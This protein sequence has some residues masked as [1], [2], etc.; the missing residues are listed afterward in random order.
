MRKILYTNISPV[1]KAYTNINHM[2]LV[3]EQNPLKCYMC[4]W[5]NFVF[6]N[7]AFVSGNNKYSKLNENTRILE[8]LLNSFNV[9]YKKFNFSEAW[10]RLFRN[11]EFSTAYQK[12][13]SNIT[14]HDIKSGFNLKYSPFSSV[15][16]SKINYIIADYLIAAFLP[17]LFPELC[18]TTPTH[19]L[20]S[21]R[22]KIFHKKISS[23]LKNKNL[24]K[25]IY[26]TSI[27]IIINPKTFDIP[28]IGDSGSFIK[29]TVREYMQDKKI[30]PREVNDIL[31]TLVKPGIKLEVKGKKLNFNSAFNKMKSLDK[32]T[33]VEEL[34]YNL[35]NYFSAVEKLEKKPKR[36]K[37]SI[38]IVTRDDFIRQVKPLNEMKLNILSYCDGTN[39]SL[40]ISNRTGIK[41]STV[42]TYFSR[43][44]ER[45][46]ITSNKKP[47]RTVDKFVIELKGNTLP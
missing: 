47:E 34:T 15:N 33:F 42:S 4:V 7:P 27:P 3:K 40:D 39:T 31:N 36:S 14:M 1:T 6:E 35:L 5:D 8:H 28:A 41:L 44:R 37:R 9:N 11:K 18:N 16:L 2:F 30:K 29:K 24:P 43:L 19:Y 17:K 23:V 21:E 38:Y 22:F 13:L 12:V 20:T 45:G 32:E 26:I 46:L 10:S 25:P